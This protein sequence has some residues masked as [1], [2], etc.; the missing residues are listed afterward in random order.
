MAGKEDGKG[1]DREVNKEGTEE[2]RLCE[3]CGKP[4]TVNRDYYD[5]FERMHWLCFHIVFEHRE[6]PD[7]PCSDPSCPW[8]HH[9]VYRRK[10]RRLGYDPDE[11]IGEA[12]DEAIE[13][14][15]GP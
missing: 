9:E 8:W 1:G 11:V 3:L 4:V 5:V 2:A 6:D 12:I 10:L 15:Y 13:E 7:R 14:L